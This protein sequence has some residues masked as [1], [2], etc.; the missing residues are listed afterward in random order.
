MHSNLKVLQQLYK[1]HKNII[2]HLNHCLKN[3]IKCN[4]I[5]KELG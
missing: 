1:M 5:R 4:I 3:I 2:K